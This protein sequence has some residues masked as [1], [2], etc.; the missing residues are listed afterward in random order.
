MVV[1]FALI[2]LIVNR[3][4]EILK[5]VPPY[6]NLAEDWQHLIT[7][8]V[9]LIAGVVAC[10]VTNFNAVTTIPTTDLGG[11]I[12]T[13]V[14]AAAFANGLAWVAD[15][16]GIARASFA[17]RAAATAPAKVARVSNGG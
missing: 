8:V 14:G 12:L 2:V 9:S 6:A 4:V 15:L 16:F 3:A 10:V 13:G 5:R 17:A 11:Q 7:Y 1:D